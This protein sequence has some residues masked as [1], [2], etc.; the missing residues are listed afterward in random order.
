[1]ADKRSSEA[2]RTLALL[3][4]ILLPVCSAPNLSTLV[5]R[6]F[7]PVGQ[8]YLVHDDVTLIITL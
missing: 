1:M 4:M 2:G 8:A 7:H 3:L 6:V 5:V